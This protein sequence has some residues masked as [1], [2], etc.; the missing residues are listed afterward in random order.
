MKNLFVEISSSNISWDTRYLSHLYCGSVEGQLPFTIKTSPAMETVPYAREFTNSSESK[1]DRCVNK[2]TEGDYWASDRSTSVGASYKMRHLHIKGKSMH[3]SSFLDGDHI[4]MNT[5]VEK[6]ACCPA[7]LNEKQCTRTF[8]DQRQLTILW[9]PVYLGL[10]RK[11]MKHEYR[12]K[13]ITEELST[14]QKLTIK[15]RQS[16][17]FSFSSI[18]LV[19][20]SLLGAIVAR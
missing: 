6:P 1:N 12:K 11:Y 14:G 10:L 16:H 13:G 3:K 15:S 5:G 9:I 4:W 18:S 19:L 7:H 20:L 2:G 17:L 8:I